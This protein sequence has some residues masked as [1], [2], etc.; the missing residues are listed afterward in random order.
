M[1]ADLVAAVAVELEAFARRTLVLV[2]GGAEFRLHPWVRLGIDAQYT[3]ISGIL[4]VAGVSQAFDET[5]LGG[6]AVRVKI[7]AGR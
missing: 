7:L 2:V 5:N 1:R 6:T 3:H 4:G